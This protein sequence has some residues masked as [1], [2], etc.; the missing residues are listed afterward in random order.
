[1]FAPN[2]FLGFVI[3]YAGISK[4]LH[5][6]ALT[7]LPRELA[8]WLKSDLFWGIQLFQY[9]W[10][11]YRKVKLLPKVCDQLKS[12]FNEKPCMAQRVTKRHINLATEG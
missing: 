1:M 12:R 11:G 2:G 9:I 6:V 10:N 8:Y 3:G 5:D 4:L 7:W